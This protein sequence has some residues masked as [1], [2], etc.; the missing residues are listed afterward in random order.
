MRKAEGRGSDRVHLCIIHRDRQ[1][2][3]E[4]CGYLGKEEP[5]FRDFYPT[6]ELGFGWRASGGL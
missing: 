5:I 1:E 6:K 2:S 4:G 3:G